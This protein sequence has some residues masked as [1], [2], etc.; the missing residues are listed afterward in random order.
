MTD[1]GLLGRVPGAKEWTSYRRLVTALHH[2]EPD[3]VPFDLG[4][5]MVTGINVRAL[6][7]L[8]SARPAGEAQVLDWVTQMARPGTMRDL[9]GCAKRRPNAGR[10]GPPGPRWVGDHD[11]LIDEF[12]I[13]WQMPGTGGT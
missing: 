11:R 13:G 2:R 7:A 4:G 6:T 12:G 10:A 9:G 3:R 1:D 8:R 5:S